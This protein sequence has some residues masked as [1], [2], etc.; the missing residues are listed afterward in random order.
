[1]PA[2]LEYAKGEAAA[3]INDHLDVAMA[4]AD[5]LVERGILTGVEVDEIIVA[6]LAR[7]ALKNELGRAFNKARPI[8]PHRDWKA[9]VRT[10]GTM[11]LVWAIASRI[12]TG[13]EINLNGVPRPLL[14]GERM[15][16]APNKHEP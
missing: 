1:M 3:L 4:I 16:S 9:D 2:F 13:A 6:T 7:K 15:F 14:L 11:R 10:G 5:G 12:S 8:S